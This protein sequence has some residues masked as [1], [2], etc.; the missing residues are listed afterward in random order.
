MKTKAVRIIKNKYAAV[1]CAVLC[2]SFWGTA[3]PLIK[4]GYSLLDI[5]D[6]DIGS[7]V[8]FAGVRFLLA[9]IMAF[10]M[11]LC[12]SPGSMM[13]GKSSIIPVAGLGLVQTF[14]QYLFSAIGVGMT[15]ATNTSIITGA[16]SLVSV[17]MAGI[18][19]AADRLNFIK[20][21]GCVIGFAGI[22]LINI[23]GASFG[24]ATLAGDIMVLLST[25]CGASGNIITKKAGGIS[26][27]AMTAWQLTL[28]GICLTALGFGLGGAI[29]FSNLVAVGIIM[30]LAFVSAFSFL[31]WT[32]LLKYHPVSK[33]AVFNMLVPI[34]GT[35]ISGV[36]LGED[37]FKIQNLIALVLISAGIIMVNREKKPGK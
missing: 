33:I 12:I 20:I 27:A 21:S 15:S 25:I 10:A 18:F 23:A 29:D 16:T 1:L 7:M 4:Y 28:G 6:S 35:V 32:A 5:T 13:I 17:I 34:F 2:T 37:I 8:L 3:F 22:I 36:V 31:L 19:F 11:G 30:W 14:M 26:P 9:G 24:G